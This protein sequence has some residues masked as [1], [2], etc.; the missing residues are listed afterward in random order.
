[1]VFKRVRTSA[2]LLCCYSIILITIQTTVVSKTL[3]ALAKLT[4]AKCQV[5]N[6]WTN[7]YFG[8]A[9][10]FNYPDSTQKPLFFV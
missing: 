2:D 10:F 6:I 9:I 1:M 7:T 8:L 4:W 3:D 5:K